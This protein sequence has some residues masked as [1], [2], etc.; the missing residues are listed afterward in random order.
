MPN[1]RDQGTMQPVGGANREANGTAERTENPATG[2]QPAY[3]RAPDQLPPGEAP[4]GDGTAD[5]LD[6]SIAESEG[7]AEGQ[8]GQS[9]SW[10]IQKAQEIYT[11][12]TDY[13]DANIT[14]TWERNLSHF[15]NEHASSSKMNGKSYKRSRIFRPKTRSTIKKSESALAAAAFS[16]QDYMQV[17][18]EDDTDEVQRLSAEINKRILQYRL[19]RRMPWFQTVIG[20]WQDTKVYGI[21]ITHNYWA[22]E[23]DTEYEPEV[24]EEGNAVTDEEGQMLG[25]PIKTVRRDELACDNVAPENFRFDPMCD[26]RDPAGTSPYLLYMMPIYVDEALERME[27][28]DP[29]TGKPVWKMHTK[30]ALLS[31]RRQNYDRTRQAREGRERIDPADEQS[32]TNYTKLWAHMNII[33]IKGDDYV[34]WTMGTELV[35]TQPVKLTEAYPHLEPGTRPFTIGVSTIEAHRNYP[36]GDAEQMAGIQAEINTIANQRLDNVKLVLNK[37]YYVRRGSQVDLD[38]LI[39]NTPGGGVMMND[40]EKDIKTVDTRDVTG[41]SYQEQ[42]RLAVEA[43]ELTGNFSQGSIQTNRNL[44]ETVGGMG[45]MQQDAGSVG[46]YGIKI[47][48]ETWME[49]TL[50]Q[51]L[52]MIQAYETDTVLLSLAAKGTELWQ[53]YG[54]DQVTDDI[55]QKDLTLKVDVGIGMTDPVRRVERLLYAVEKTASLPGM[56]ERMKSPEI[57]NEIFGT[58]GYRDGSRFYMGDEEFG[59]VQEETKAQQGPPPE[60]ALKQRELDIRE[61]DTNKR[62]ER[63]ERRLEMDAHFGHAELALKHN[64]KLEELHARLGTEDKKIQAA[65]DTAA[66]NANLKVAELAHARKH[67]Q[68]I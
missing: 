49:P 15:N 9:S 41:S 65:R 14:N 61:M 20:A 13:L 4:G 28:L 58:L 27:R 37:R 2:R 59:R 40:P 47:F 30:G 34:Y 48:M 39:R 68:G 5:A 55:L 6:D 60:I 3:S 8:D 46:D 23:V 33:R 7:L 54:V 26:W 67:G 21:C 17:S 52:K 19:D 63:E 31:T 62:H 12:S 25:R 18:A 24:D 43:D 53:K 22:Y 51:F 44:N 16:T 1:P 64:L 45:M 29:K 50:R 35:L 57:T 38:A 36:A 42:D 32:G 11:N 66:V 10:L 56:V